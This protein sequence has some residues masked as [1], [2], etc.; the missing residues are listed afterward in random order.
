MMH[1]FD[2]DNT[3]VYTNRANNAAY[4]RALALEGL[5]PILSEG[6]ITRVTVKA[7]YPELTGEQLKRVIA[8]KQAHFPKEQTSVNG[9]LLAYVRSLGRER[10][11][12]W[13]SADQGRARA[14][15][16]YYGLEPCFSTLYFSEKTHVVQELEKLAQRFSIKMR[17]LTVY[18][19]TD[20]YI[21]ELRAH[22]VRAVDAKR[23]TASFVHSGQDTLP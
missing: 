5:A 13:S 2:F 15:V 10:C 6:R 11:L 3:L 1:I 17:D 23:W 7:A 16:E 4:N 19:D 20:P 9:P 14:L 18:E 21:E 22:G 8:N 12:L